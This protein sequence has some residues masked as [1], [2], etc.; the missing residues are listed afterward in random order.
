MV[1]VAQRMNT[2]LLVD[3]VHHR[4]NTQLS[5]STPMN[6]DEQR[7]RRV[8]IREVMQDEALTPFEKR[9]SVQALMD[10]RRRSSEAVSSIRT[11]SAANSMSMMAAAAAAAAEFYDS[12]DDNEN[13]L[14][15]DDDSLMD[16]ATDAHPMDYSTRNDIH[17]V[18][19]SIP[20]NGVGRRHSFC[21]GASEITDPSLS[22]GVT[23]G[24]FG[25]RRNSGASSAGVH[26]L[27]GRKQGRSASLRGFAAGAAAAAAAAV[28]AF[29]EGPEDLMAAAQRMEKSRLKCDHYE[30]NCTIISPCCG[31]AFGC[32][33]CHDDS[34]CLPPPIILNNAISSSSK[35]DD[36]AWKDMAKK[37][38][39]KLQNRKAI[40][41]N[42]SEE[43]THHTI[44]RFSI[45]E[46]I[47]RSCF[48]R[49]NSKT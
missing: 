6:D 26:I 7:E 3:S 39:L 5:Q 14:R 11:G 12:S 38:D 4:A 25:T 32:R 45:K 24:G 44:D 16:D 48:C 49:Q 20:R 8:S 35:P 28:A 23:G 1:S 43:E 21:G 18:G 29:S 19:G 9:K 22:V 36:L 47:C 31:L 17:S 37:T 10:G 33:I 2:N 40:P 41:N 46:V 27:S 34:P 30:R 13:D 42:L 15:D